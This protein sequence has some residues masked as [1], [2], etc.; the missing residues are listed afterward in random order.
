M[1]IVGPVHNRDHDPGYSFVGTEP[2]ARRFRGKRSYLYA[3]QDVSNQGGST[4][5]GT[6]GGPQVEPNFYL[7]NMPNTSVNIHISRYVP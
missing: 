4:P 6:P 3:L 7:H 2:T 1:F 5:R